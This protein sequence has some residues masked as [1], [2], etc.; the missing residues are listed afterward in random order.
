M[1]ENT[2]I[3]VVSD[4]HYEKGYHHGVYEFGALEWLLDTVKKVRPSELVGLG[5]WGSAWTPRDWDT[6]TDMVR[7]HGIY[8]NHENMEVLRSAR[9]PDGTHVLAKDG[10]I[11]EVCGLRFGFINGITSPNGESVNSVPTKT[12]DMYRAVSR[13]LRGVDVLCTHL[14]PLT[15]E[16]GSRIRPEEGVLVAREIIIDLHPSLALS[17]HLSGPYT[18]SRIGSTL[19]IRVDSSQLTKH[20][21]LI[22]PAERVVEVWCDNKKVLHENFGGSSL[23]SRNP[24]SQTG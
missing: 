14:S 5:D 21:A 17:G 13:R 9:N 1:G 8:G 15:A 7:V 22:R 2:A 12:P 4:V 3:M 24:G 23:G 16:Y 20:F 11:H 10:E 18:V 19:S 6:L